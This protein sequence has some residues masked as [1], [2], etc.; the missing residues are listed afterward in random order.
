M[1]MAGW[2]VFSESYIWDDELNDRE[3]EILDLIR[4]HIGDS[5]TNER[6]QIHRLNYHTIILFALGHNHYRNNDRMIDL[7]R[8]I[9]EVASGSYG[10][11]HVHDEEGEFAPFETMTVFVLARGELTRYKDPFFT[12][13]IPNVEGPAPEDDSPP[14]VSERIEKF[15]PIGTIVTLNGDD[16]KQMIVGH[17]Q[18]DTNND[19]VFDYVG[20]PYPEGIVAPKATFLFNHADIAWVHYLGYADEDET[21]CNEKLQTPPSLP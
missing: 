20:C 10:Q 13:Y 18:N 4:S 3:N 1:F 5:V 19:E 2:I 11:L 16:K 14:P 17:L 7:F 12:P 6:V 21:A 9:G 15:L 8:Y